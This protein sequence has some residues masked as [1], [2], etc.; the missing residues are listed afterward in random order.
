MPCEGPT[1]AIA[2][3]AFLPIGPVAPDL[4]RDVV[5]RVS[6]AVSVPCRLDASVRALPGDGAPPAA[7]AGRDQWD[8]DRLLADLEARCAEPPGGAPG[9][10]A[11]LV[12][13]AARDIGNAVFTHFF[14]RARLGGRAALVSLARLTPEFYGLPADADAT[15]RRAAL[16]VLHEL[17]HVAGL[18]HCAHPGCLMRLAHHVEAIDLRGTS[19]CGACRGRLPRDLLRD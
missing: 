19:F 4:A 6:R 17:G 18:G 8:A 16:E 2:S 14:G 7:V 11:V 1:A 10:G 3:L 13:L 15:A 5:V 9:D 12:G